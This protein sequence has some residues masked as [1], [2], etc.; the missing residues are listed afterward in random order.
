MIDGNIDNLIPLLTMEIK[1]G[2]AF[3]SIIQGK[4][5]D[6]YLELDWEGIVKFIIT[7]IFYGIAL[8]YGILGDIDLSCTN[9]GSKGFLIKLKNILSK[10]VK[11][12]NFSE[13]AIATIIQNDPSMTIKQKKKM[14]E[15]ALF[16]S[17]KLIETTIIAKKLFNF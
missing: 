10:I 7:N 1:Y 6:E 16:P 4:E 17:K 3:T 11:K 2:N 5:R 15:L 13:R 9:T 8:K 14:M 12:G